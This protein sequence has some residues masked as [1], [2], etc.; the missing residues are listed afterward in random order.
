PGSYPV[1]IAN[2]ESLI[3]DPESLIHNRPSSVAD[4]ES[5]W[6]HLARGVAIRDGGFK[7]LD[8]GL[9]IRDPGSV[10][11]DWRCYAYS[12]LGMPVEA[13]VDSTGCPDH[14][15]RYGHRWG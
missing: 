3:P 1:I 15:Q 6:A 13:V 11:R 4:R 9:R 5:G 8:A 12:Q 10:I 7:T 14:A 2:R